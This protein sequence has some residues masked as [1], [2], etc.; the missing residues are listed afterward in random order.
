LF[1][2]YAEPMARAAAPAIAALL[3]AEIPHQVLQYQHDPRN[4][5]FGEEA[6]EELARVVEGNQGVAPQQVFKTLVVALPKGLAVAVTN[7]VTADICA[8]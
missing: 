1:P 7:A 5:S 8:P 2:H 6:V 3:T 4:E